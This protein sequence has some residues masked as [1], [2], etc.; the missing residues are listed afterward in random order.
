MRRKRA[1]C[2]APTSHERRA[3]IV[4]DSRRKI[5]QARRLDGQTWT[6]IGDKKAWTL[7]GS[8]AWPI[9]LREAAPFPLIALVEG[10]PDLLVAFHLVWCTG[11]QSQVAPVA[12]LGAANDIPNEALRYF[13]ERRVRILPHDD[14]DGR[15]AEAGWAAQLLAAGADVDGFSFAGL[16]RVDDKPIKDLNDFAHVHPDQ[17]EAERDA[18]EQAFGS[19]QKHD[20]ANQ[21]LSKA[22]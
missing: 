15:D 21:N 14:R 8:D 2:G 7:P 3:W 19:P 9:G 22:G 20:I 5:A 11:V 12:I 1:C 6:Q 10:G 16:L 13:A 18:L 4:T 17:W